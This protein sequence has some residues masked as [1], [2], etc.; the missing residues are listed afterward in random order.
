MASTDVLILPHDP[1]WGRRFAAE[2]ARLLVLFEGAVLGV[3][4]VGSTAVPGLAAKPVLDMLLVTR[5]ESALD[6]WR[7][8][9]EGLGYRWHGEAGIRGRRYLLL[10][11]PDYDAVH[12]HAF[13]AGHPE[14]ERH[15]LFRDYLL[16]HP[17]RAAAYGSLKRE[18]A[19]LH[20]SDRA[21][22]TEA[23]TA[24]I[25]ETEVLARGWSARRRPA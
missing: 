12:V 19:R 6:G 9:A 17:R 22:Y 24:F 20:R 8:A 21:A 7:A 11:G 10:P 16:A 14:I 2:A 25:R 4:H 3:H 5:A 18:L 15:V 23:K 1:S 13:P